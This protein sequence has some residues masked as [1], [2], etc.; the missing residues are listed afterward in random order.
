[1]P[2]ISA[3]CKALNNTLE[4]MDCSGE[5]KALLKTP[6]RELIVELPLK[7]DDGSIAIF[8]G[9]R[10]QDNNSRGP[11][12]GGLRFNENVDLDHFRDL[13]SVMTWKTALVDIPFG[14]AKGGISCN[15]KD[16]SENEL[17]TLTKRFIEKTSMLF[18]PSLDIPAPDMGTGPREM[19]WLMSAFEKLHGYSPGAV[20]GKP[21]EFGGIE[22]RVEA[23]GKGVALFTKWACEEEDIDLSSRRVAIHGFGNV[24]SHAA[25]I[26][27]E[28]GATIVAASDASGG[29]YNPKGLDITELR[30]EQGKEFADREIEGEKISSSDVLSIDCDILI[31]AAI[32][33]T[34]TKDNANSVK[35]RLIVEAANLPTTTEAEEILEEKGVTIV[36]D[37]LANSGGVTVSFFE[38]AQNSQNFPWKKEKV[39]RE[40][41]SLLKSAWNN[42]VQSRTEAKESYRQ[43]AYDIAINRVR[44][45]MLKKGFR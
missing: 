43:T 27:S 33:N 17:E 39:D 10:V 11:Y 34:L 31:P 36:P 20:T 30:S 29:W 37:I 21:V 2:Q 3:H 25:M 15:P 16:L 4:K 1:M 26:L 7:K 35:A 42:L 41:E 40:L 32:E 19:T 14:G 22:G 44:V 5:M 9:Y 8:K 13:A 24:G 6:Q 45:A 38:W 12:K 23:T 18:G 28:M